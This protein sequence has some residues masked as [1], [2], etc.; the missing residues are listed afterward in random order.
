MAA[1]GVVA[2]GGC[3]VAVKGPCVCEWVC[4]VRERPAAGWVMQQHCFWGCSVARAVVAAV[5]QELR[6]STT[7][8]GELSCRHVWLLQSPTA[9]VHGGVWGVVCA[10]AVAAMEG[11]R[12]CMW[13][14]WYDAQ[15]PQVARQ[16]TLEQSWARGAARVAGGAAPFAPPLL[17]VRAAVQRRAGGVAVADLWGRLQDVAGFSRGVPRGW[18]PE[19]VGPQ[20]PFLGLRPC[21]PLA[22]QEALRF[23]MCFTALGAGVGRAD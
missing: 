15:R 4:G 3:G 14:L 22:G 16:L 8:Q 19:E 11:G 6:R 12:R 5:Q 17:S 1:Q 20:H 10:A 23:S 18:S 9:E 13:R 7:W 21:P 2:A